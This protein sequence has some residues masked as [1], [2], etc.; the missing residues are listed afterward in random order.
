MYIII[1][2][3]QVLKITLLCTAG[4]E[5][6]DQITEVCDV[7]FQFVNFDSNCQI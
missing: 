2:C 3:S 5:L 7:K 4:A 1:C 6:S